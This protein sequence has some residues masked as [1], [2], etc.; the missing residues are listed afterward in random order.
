MFQSLDG[1][2]VGGV[3]AVS[4]TTVLLRAA[5]VAVAINNADDVAN[6]FLVNADT[7]PDVVFAFVLVDDIVAKADSAVFIIVSAAAT[8]VAVLGMVS[9]ETL[10]FTHIWVLVSEPYPHYQ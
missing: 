7:F 5:E 10:A 4:I 6:A 1:W 2:V 9:L 3:F 8:T